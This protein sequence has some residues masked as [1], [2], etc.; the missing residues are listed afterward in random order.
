M[1]RKSDEAEAE[2]RRKKVAAN[3][4][5]GNNYRDIA[6]GLKCSIGTVS[7]DARVIIRRWQKEQVDTA[8]RWI[9]LQCRRLDAAINYMWEDIKKGDTTAIARMQAVIEQQGKL[10]GYEKLLAQLHL[11][12]NFQDLPDDVLDRMA[13]GENV[14]LA[15]IARSS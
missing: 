2:D 11:N 13:K 5:A 6:E 4:L 7:N 3:L 8:D 10:L 9:A 15:A 12:V 14:D 1:S